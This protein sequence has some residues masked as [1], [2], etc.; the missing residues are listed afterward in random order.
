MKRPL[1]P[2]ALLYASGILIALLIP[3]PPLPLLVSSLS[4]AVLTLAW[5]RARLVALGTLI[6]LTGWTN[7]ALR[8]AIISPHDLR[9]ILGEQPEIV[10]LRGMLSETPTQRVYERNQ[11]ESWRTMSRI[12][13]TALRRNRQHWQP[14]AGRVAVTTLGILSTNCFVGQEVEITGVAGPPRVAVAEG[15]FDYRAYLKQQGIYYQ[16]QAAG[17]PDWRIIASPSMPPLA[18]RFREWARGALALCLPAEDE[19]LRLEWALTLG[20][21]TALT[22]EV[23]EPFVQAA[24]YH[25]FAVDGLRMAII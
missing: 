3:V 7:H 9:R 21:K 15:M 11:E 23:S 20:W 25:I 13:V 2:V 1:V 10:T 18:D 4:L 16:L 8:T 6:V 14:A 22:E 5:P 12:D 17:E 24:T 19:S